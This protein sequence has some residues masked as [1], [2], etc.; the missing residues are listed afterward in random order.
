M[1]SRDRREITE[2]AARIVCVE[3]ITDYRQAKRKA[4]QR[5]GLPPQAPLPDNAAVHAAV[6]EYQ[7]LF[8]GD[9]YHRQLRRLR[10][11][12]LAAMSLFAGHHPQLAGAA[13]SGA[14][15][16]AHRVQLHVFCDSAE[17]IDIEL[18]N[19]GIPFETG[20]R[21]YRYPDGRDIATPLLRLEL[22]GCGVDVAVFPEDG[23]RRVPINP[24]DGRAF[25]R[26]D[27]A[28]LER[29]LAESIADS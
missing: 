27:R 4:A 29:L 20:E 18:L 25:R 3:L 12:A 13:V 28:A 26:L 5:L 7:Q 11:T 10:E 17:A 9:D 14:V 24:L 1:S 8:G 6:I 2:E 23:R 21:S 19:C 15:T 16:E 22:D